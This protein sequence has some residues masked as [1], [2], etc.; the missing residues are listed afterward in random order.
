MRKGLRATRSGLLAAIDIGTSKV[1]CLIARCDKD[2]RP[3]VVGI[4]QQ[5]NHGVRNG[6]VTDM[7][8]TET[9]IVNAV[10]AAEQMAGETIEQVV[11]NLSGGYPAS[12]SVDVEVAIAGHAVGESDLK[13]ALEQGHQAGLASG[14]N[15]DVREL[16]HSIPVGYRIDGNRGIRDPRGLF[17]D[18]LGVNIHFVTAASGAVR[19]LIA[20]VERCHL[21][22]ADVAVSPYASGLSSLVDDEMALGVTLIDM[23]GG[24][25]TIAV[26]LEGSVIFTD[27]LRVGGNHV[28]SDIAR[29]VSTPLAQAERIKTLYG[30]AMAI[31]ADELIEVPQVGEDGDG[32]PHQIPRSLL[33]GIVQPRLEETFELVRSRLEAG[34]MD[35]ISGRRVVLTGGACQL[36]GIQELA[37][38]ILDKQIRIGRPI[39]VSGLAEATSGP[40]YTTAAGLLVYAATAERVTTRIEQTE[41]ETAGGLLGRLGHWFREHL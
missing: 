16:I 17:G 27:V 20:C 34:G 21:E 9:A 25:T 32:Q 12:S 31:G 38:L 1:C 29:G 11:I 14:L 36:P 8:A 3:A 40:A 18:R 39:R 33:V 30:H 2:G 5:A 15:G 7:D 37:H 24:T 19:N 23:G 13:R 28:T 26:F 35:K 10:H 6:A 22:V 41:R 4:G